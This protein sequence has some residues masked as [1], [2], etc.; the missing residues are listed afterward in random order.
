MQETRPKNIK[1]IVL[2]LE[3]KKIDFMTKWKKKLF[4]CSGLHFT[5]FRTL[6]NSFLNKKYAQKSITY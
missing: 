5:F 2:E 4:V 6:F 1:V 3:L